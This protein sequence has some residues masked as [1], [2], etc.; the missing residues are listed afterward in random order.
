MFGSMLDLIFGSMDVQRFVQRFVRHFARYLVRY[1]VKPVVAIALCGAIA[2]C[3]N[4]GPALGE[5]TQSPPQIRTQ[6]SAPGSAKATFAGGCFWCMEQPFD[7]LPGVIS[8]T[9]GYTGGTQPN[10]TYKQ[11]SSG[12][13]GHTESV[14][15]EYNPAQV[16]YETLLQT[17]WHNID[18]LDAKGQFCDKGNQYRSAIFYETP[19]QKKLAQTSKQALEKSGQFQQPIATEIVAAS[20]FYPAED[21]HQ[22]FYQTHTAKY[23]FYRLGCG[24]DRRLQQVWGDAA[25][26]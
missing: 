21:Y 14:R 22:N 25:G 12:T 16:S 11:V 5:P 7:Q 6:S 24:R 19:K 20:T 23:K 13:T 1:W 3:S 8:T 2:S 4:S 17:Y 15:V 26:H 10:P 18:P 9:S